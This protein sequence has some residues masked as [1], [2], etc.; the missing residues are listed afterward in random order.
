MLGTIGVVR[1]GQGGPVRLV[2]VA[3]PGGV[4]AEVWVAL[5]VHQAGLVNQERGPLELLTPHAPVEVGLGLLELVGHGAEG[6]AREHRVLVSHAEVLRQPHPT[7]GP[8]NGA[9][10][11]EPGSVL[12]GGSASFSGTQPGGGPG[13]GASVL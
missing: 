3:Q 5:P 6:A 2:R 13:D 7:C 10:G 9:Y 11:W 1:G 12:L 4:M 8:E